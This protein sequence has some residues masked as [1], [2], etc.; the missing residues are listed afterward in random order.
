NGQIEAYPLENSSLGIWYHQS[1]GRIFYSATVTG[2][3]VS[4]PTDR[5]FLYVAQADAPRVLY[6]VETNAEI[7]APPAELKPLL[8]VTSRDGYL[9]CLHGLTG[10]E[11]WRV[12]TG[13]PI[14]KKP[15]VVANTAY[16]ASQQ[17]ALHAVNS[18]TGARLWSADRAT[19]FVAEGAKHVY[20]MDRYGTLFILDRESGGTIGRLHAGEGATALVNDQSDRIYLVSDRG[21]VQCLHEIDSPEPTYY[22]LQTVEKDPED[23]AKTVE[24]PFVEKTPDQEFTLPET[25]DQPEVPFEP[26]EDDDENPFF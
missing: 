17:P 1:A 26:S 21:L 10:A 5:G 15:A 13:Y 6:R 16:V 18:Q 9:Y 8:Y 7:V 19:Q 3:L 20:A 25:T 14:V 22:R 12:S 2:N 24:S 4:W 11:Q 23:D